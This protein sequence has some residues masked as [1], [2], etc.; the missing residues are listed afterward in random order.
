M[1]YDYGP[2]IMHHLL[3]ACLGPTMILYVKLINSII[4][5]IEWTPKF[6]VQFLLKIYSTPD[7]A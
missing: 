4:N 1:S 6:G 2:Y 7:I 5:E 3:I